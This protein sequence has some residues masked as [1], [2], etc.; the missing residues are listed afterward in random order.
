MNG[1]LESA[2]QTHKSVARLRISGS[3]SNRRCYVPRFLM[4]PPSAFREAVK[5]SAAPSGTGRPEAFRSA[6]GKPQVPRTRVFDI[7]HG[8]WRSGVRHPSLDDRMPIT[9]RKFQKG[10]SASKIGNYS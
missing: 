5:K 10:R 3:S 4:L 7:F 8:D 2:A 1:R 9:A 6:G